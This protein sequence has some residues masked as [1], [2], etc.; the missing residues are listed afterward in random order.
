MTM[1]DN[2]LQRTIVNDRRKFR[3]Q[4][5]DNMDR[6]KSRGGKSQR[7]EKKKGD[8][9]RERVRGKKMQAREKVEKSRPTCFSNGVVR[10]TFGSQ[11]VESTSRSD[12]EVEMSQSA[13]HCGT[14]HISKSKCAEHT[15]FG[16]LLEDEMSKKC[17][18]LW[19]EAHFHVKMLKTPHARTAFEASD[20]VLRGRRKGF[21]ILPKV[22]KT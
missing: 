1:N 6:W 21:C 16:A 13:R 15:R 12:L 11:N 4:T 22:S 8:Q 17:T 14:K 3:S 7:R 19:R 20:V 2:E 9:R 5:S 18:P 10:S